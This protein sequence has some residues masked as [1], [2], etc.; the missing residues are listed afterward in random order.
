M[1][2]L[3]EMLG[4]HRCFTKREHVTYSDELELQIFRCQ[5]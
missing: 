3:Q 1:Y 2:I 4:K 5:R